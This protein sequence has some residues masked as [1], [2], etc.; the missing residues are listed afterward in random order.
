MCDS[1]ASSSSSSSTSTG[2]ADPADAALYGEG[3]YHN[4]RRGIVLRQI[5]DDF[6]GLFATEPLPAG[7][8]LWKNRADGP[9]EEQYRKIYGEDLRLLS[10]EELKYFIRYSYQN[11]DEFFISPLC[12][13]E[14]DLDYSNYWNHSCFP[15]TLPRDEDHWVAC[16]D[17]AAG[18]QVR[19]K[20]KENTNSI[21][22]WGVAKP[23]ACVESFAMR[24]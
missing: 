9:A 23:Q 17:I 16:R 11:D 3:S 6:Q 24:A 15:N 7:T 12:A 13:E 1:S 5:S 2:G 4:I 19:K 21:C 20:R 18:E 10:A 14:V 8:V 22:F